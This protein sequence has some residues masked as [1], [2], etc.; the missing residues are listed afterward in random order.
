MAAHPFCLAILRDVLDDTTPTGGTWKI[1]GNY[2]QRSSKGGSSGQGI[3]E[4]LAD[5]AT[6][7]QQAAERKCDEVAVKI[8][9]LVFGRPVYSPLLK[10]AD[11]RLAAMKKLL[12]RYQGH[13]RRLT[14]A[15]AQ[16][17][18]TRTLSTMFVPG[19]SPLDH[20]ATADDVAKGRAVFHLDG[21][22][23]PAGMKL[24]AVAML[25]QKSSPEPLRVLVVQAEV[26]P[27]GET[28]YGII[29]GG[30]DSR[31]GRR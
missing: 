20:A 3:P 18:E 7:R 25:H 1:E 22:V 21:Q 8:G 27:D 19:I 23:K 14:E 26:G 9:E 31:G 13:F 15:E 24:P 4:Y 11:S 12:D 17:L 10:D 16:A 5:P 6:R 2:L 30:D 29:G 28:T